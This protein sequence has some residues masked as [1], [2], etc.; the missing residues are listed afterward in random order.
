MRVQR[1]DYGA[2]LRTVLVVVTVVIVLYLIYLVRRPLLW[3]LMAMFLA[4]ALATL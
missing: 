2:V 4:V 3:V 1:F